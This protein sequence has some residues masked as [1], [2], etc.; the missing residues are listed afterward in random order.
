MRI[1]RGKNTK[2][3]GPTL[4][5]GCLQVAV[6]LCQ[7][8]PATVPTEPRRTHLRTHPAPRW[9]RPGS[10]PKNGGAA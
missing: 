7:P 5:A 4:A 1:L 3:L 6:R 10:A 9:Y 8:V 2:L